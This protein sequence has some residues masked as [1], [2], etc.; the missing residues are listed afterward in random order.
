[1]NLTLKRPIFSSISAGVFNVCE[2]FKSEPISLEDLAVEHPDFTFFLRVSG[3]S[4]EPTINDRD[5]VACDRLY[6][7]A[8]G[9]DHLQGEVL[10]IRLEN[11]FILK[12]FY[13]NN[14]YFKLVADNP[15]YK[16]LN[17]PRNETSDLE[18]IGKVVSIIRKL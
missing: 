10:A 2:D 3:I 5:I 12:R 4:M 9:L 11:E 18:L 16:T 15:T 6:V 14:E 13:S 17:I 7:T 1:M 8:E